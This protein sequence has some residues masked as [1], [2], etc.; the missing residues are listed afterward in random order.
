MSGLRS[1]IV[2][3]YYALIADYWPDE[4]RWDQLAAEANVEG[5]L[6]RLLI[7]IGP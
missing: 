7:P 3:L 1:H 6:D 4:A 2:H 5:G